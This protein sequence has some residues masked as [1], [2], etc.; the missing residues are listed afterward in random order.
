MAT[1]LQSTPPT[2]I[3]MQMPDATQQFPTRSIDPDFRP[4]VMN[5]LKANLGNILFTWDLGENSRCK[6]PQVLVVVILLKSVESIG[7]QF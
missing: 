6:G 3:I 7:H 5:G 1:Q 2:P 4:K